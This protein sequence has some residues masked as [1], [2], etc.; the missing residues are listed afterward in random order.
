MGASVLYRARRVHTL[1]GSPATQAIAVRDGVIAAI[2]AWTELRDADASDVVDLGDATIVPGLIDAHIHPIGGLGLTR[3]TDLRACRTL[4]DVERMLRAAPQHEAG[5]WLLGWGL[6]PNVFSGAPNG[7]FLDLVAPGRPAAVILF[8]V[9]SLVASTTAIERAGIT[10]HETFG[11]ASSVAVGS[12]GRPTGHLVEHGAM[13]LVQSI[14]PAASHDERV[15]LLRRNLTDMAGTGFTAGHALDMGADDAMALLT[16]VAASPGGL[17]LDLTVSPILPADADE[18]AF[19]QI[20]AAQGS[21]GPRWRVSGVKL[22]ID[23]TIDNGT[24]W[25]RHPDCFGQSTSS[26]W[27]DPSR[28]RDLVRRLHAAGIPTRTHAIGDQGVDFVAHTLASLP[29]TG[30]QHRIEHLETV[31]DDTLDLLAHAGIAAGMQPT[32]CTRFVHPDGSDNWSTRLGEER[33]ARG[34]RTRDVRSR[35]ITL[36]LGSDWPVA[37]SDAREIIA[38]AQL[39]HQ[40]GAGPAIGPAQAL[41]ALQALEG[42][43]THAAA[44]IGA[45][46]PALRVGAPATFT[47]FDRD[48][49]TAPPEEFADARV[50]MTAIA[51]DVVIGADR[52]V[53]VR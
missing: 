42:F 14:I 48:P 1:D 12:D 32:H 10:G 44:S 51:G 43:T 4:D 27:L 29:R 49:L 37:P 45:P 33:A 40:V 41:T 50:T 5:P 8:D 20:V 36:A 46:S 19:A 11:D 25:L 31:T 39:R 22:L 21:G 38:A 16:D 3:G 9:H 18:A 34:W 13:A 26:L 28:Y 7:H 24:A 53:A 6:D 35:G 2:G 52:A 47:A 23:G 30:V 17:P 15:A